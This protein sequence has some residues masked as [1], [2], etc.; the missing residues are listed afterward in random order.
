MT[1]QQDWLVSVAAR[2]RRVKLLGELWER[3]PGA[4][5]IRE[6]FSKMNVP[7]IG[8]TWFQSLVLDFIDRKGTESSWVRE[9]VS[10]L[11]SAGFAT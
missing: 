9:D 4:L 7:G 5:P 3:D 2:Q 6:M 10:L 1:D 11:V 8:S